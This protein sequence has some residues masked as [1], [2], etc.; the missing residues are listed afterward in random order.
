LFIKRA[1]K[2]FR[3]NEILREVQIEGRVIRI[4]KV[5]TNFAPVLYEVKGEYLKKNNFEVLDTD[6]KDL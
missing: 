2:Y 5:T 3:Y 4:E 6:Y 1:K